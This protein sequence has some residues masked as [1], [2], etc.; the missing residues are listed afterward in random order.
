MVERGDKKAAVRKMEQHIG[1]V[2]GKFL[3]RE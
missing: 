3:S 1:S 2:R